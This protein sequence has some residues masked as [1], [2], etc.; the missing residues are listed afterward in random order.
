MKFKKGLLL[1]VVVFALGLLLSACGGAAEEAGD[2]FSFAVVMPNPL[3]D[4]SFIDSSNRGAQRAIEELG[5][6]RD[7]IRFIAVRALPIVFDLVIVQ[8]HEGRHLS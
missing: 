3:G 1:L 6:D 8:Q 4:R 5:V 2:E 7:F